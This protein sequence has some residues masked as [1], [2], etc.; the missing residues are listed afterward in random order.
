MF[1]EQQF[2][3]NM[4][5]KMCVQ[6]TT[7]SRQRSALTLVEVLLVI[8]VLSVLVIIAGLFFRDVF[9]VTNDAGTKLDQEYSMRQVLR[10]FVADIRTAEQSITGAYVIEQATEDSIIFFSDVNGDTVPERIHYLLMNNELVK[11]VYE[12][13]GTPPAYSANYTENTIATNVTNNDIFEYYSAGDVDSATLLVAPFST[14][15]IRYVLLSVT[16]KDGTVT[17]TGVALRNL[18]DSL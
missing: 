14:A 13:T 10:Q 2:G 6:M 16:L 4:Y 15:D 18:K 11:R 8:G 17:S 9:I 3:T 1:R 7:C 5:S 12:A